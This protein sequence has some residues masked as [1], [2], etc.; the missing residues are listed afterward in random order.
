MK[1]IEKPIKGMCSSVLIRTYSQHIP[2]STF[3]KLQC[4]NSQKLRDR[5]LKRIYIIIEQT[6][7]SQNTILL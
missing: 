7:L 5:N 6:L 4:R 3:K 1:K 2:Y